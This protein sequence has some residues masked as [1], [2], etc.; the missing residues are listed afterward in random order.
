MNLLLDTNVVS[1]WAKPKP[2]PHV[3]AWLHGLDEDRVYLS[4]ATF[5][6]IRYGIERLVAGI[7]RQRLTAWLEYELP[8]RFEGRILPIDLKTA[9]AWGEITALA[10]QLGRPI[11]AMDGFFA[12]T[13]KIHDLTL[14]TR[15][16]SDFDGLQIRLFD[17]WRAK[18]T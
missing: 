13:A 4:V 12:A 14:A 2:D 17:P 11:G 8:G 6:E 5:A 9:D 16:V 3:V 7:R 10:Q 1:E 18:I 15:N